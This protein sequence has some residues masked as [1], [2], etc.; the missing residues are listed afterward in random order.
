MLHQHAEAKQLYVVIHNRI[1]LLDAFKHKFDHTT[2]YSCF[3]V[4]N[5]FTCKLCLCYVNFTRDTF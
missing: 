4:H 5:G 1:P 3:T 2:K